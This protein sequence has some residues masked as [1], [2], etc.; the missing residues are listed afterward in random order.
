MLEDKIKA[1]IIDAL[2]GIPDLNG[3]LPAEINI[4]TPSLSYHVEFDLPMPISFAGA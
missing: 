3:C 1:A 4:T 2:K